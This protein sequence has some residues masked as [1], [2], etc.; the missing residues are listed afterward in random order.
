VRVLV[1]GSAGFL[2]R[3]FVQAHLASGDHVV[4]VDNMSAWDRQEVIPSDVMAVTEVIDIERWCFEDGELSLNED[5]DLAYHFAAPVGGRE[6]IEGDPLFNSGSLGIDATFFRW[7]IDRVPRVVYPSSSAVYGSRLQG[8]GA[9]Q[10][11]ERFFEPADHTW[12]APDELYGFTKLAGE[13]LAW[14][15]ATYGLDSLCIRPFSGY[16]EGQSFDYPVPAIA[17]RVLRRED[18]L[19]IWGSGQQSRDFIHVDDIVALTRARLRHPIGGYDALNLGSGSDIT[20]FGLARLFAELVGYSPTIISD[21]D[22]P[23]GV[24]RRWAS[25]ER[26][27]LYGSPQVTLRQGLARVLADVEQRIAAIPML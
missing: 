18:P 16:G 1:T 21:A 13:M 15:A 11:K 26:Q 5:F 22:K 6:K 10:L 27:K 20:F 2:G 8:D 7:A 9:S 12:S 17:A 25:I 4:G 14:K 24:T 23:E 19:V 3:H